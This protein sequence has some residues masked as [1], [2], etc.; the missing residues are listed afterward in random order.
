VS[1]GAAFGGV[2]DGSVYGMA[3]LGVVGL[4]RQQSVEGAP[5]GIAV[6][7]IAPYAKTRLG[8]GFGPIPW[9]DALGEWLHPRLVAP[10]VG[11][12]AHRDCPVTGEC[13]SVGAGHVARVSLAV[14]DGY[15]DRDATI[16]SIAAHLD[17]VMA[18]PTQEVTPTSSPVM[19][20]M[21]EG[22]RGPTA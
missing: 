15:L 1:S 7:V 2:P 4:T 9:S 13:F 22:F 11:W 20:R 6:N 10:L 16:E 12:L 21:F 14:N 3:K 8:T 18:G 5:L 17:E 19:A